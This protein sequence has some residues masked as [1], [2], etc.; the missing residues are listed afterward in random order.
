M[1]EFL[2]L[3]GLETHRNCSATLWLLLFLN[4]IDIFGTVCGANISFNYISNVTDVL[5]VHILITV[6]AL[7]S[8]DQDS[9]KL[10]DGG[11]VLSSG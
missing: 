11:L 7:A 6:V 3:F 1:L 2:A 8:G 10:K 9:Q 5:V 4:L